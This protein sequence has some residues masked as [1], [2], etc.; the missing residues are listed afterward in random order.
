MESFIATIGNFSAL[1]SSSQNELLVYFLHSD[2]K[3]HVTAKDIDALREKLRLPACGTAQQLSRGCQK[4]RGKRPRFI[5]ATVGY[6]LE[7]GV[8]EEFNARFSQ[9]P[10][11]VKITND[12]AQHIAKVNDLHLKDILQEAADCF[13]SG[14]FR[15]SM[16][17]AWAAGYGIVRGWL[18]AKHL[19]AINQVTA[20]W[21]TPKTIRNIEDF[22]ELNE[23]VVLDTGRA[24]GVLSKEEHK[25][26]V[27]LLDQR[28]SFAHPSGRKVAA[29]IAEAYLLQLIDEVIVPRI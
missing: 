8:Y 1:D 11:T 18:F 23:R 15:A 7:R 17:L 19:A 28:N 2:G 24:A 20:G 16:V 13:G 10:A 14:Y 27:A 22:E 12:L 4:S 3:E 26:L 9:R 6:K 21:R 29:S 5:K 25:Q